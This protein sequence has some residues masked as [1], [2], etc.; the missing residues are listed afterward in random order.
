MIIG[1]RIKTIGMPVSFEAVV[2]KVSWNQD[3]ER[4][5]LLVMDD[6]GELHEIVATY[7][8]VLPRGDE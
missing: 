4:H 1:R 2:V 5:D 8:K 3:E 6:A 7:A